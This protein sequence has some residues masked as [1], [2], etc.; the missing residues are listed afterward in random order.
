MNVLI[1]LIICLLSYLVESIYNNDSVSIYNT[2]SLSLTTT[3]LSLKYKWDSLLPPRLQWLHN[4]GY[5]GE[6][7]TIMAL[8]KYGNYLSQY[9]FRA[10]SSKYSVLGDSNKP[11]QTQFYLVGSNDEQSSLAVKLKYIEYDHSNRDPKVYLAWCKKMTRLGYAV[12]ITVYM[13]YYLFY[14]INDNTAGEWDYDHIVS[15]SKIES[16]YDDDEYHDDDIITLEDH[17][18]WAPRKTGPLYLF[19]YTFKDFPGTREEANT[20]TDSNKI[21]TLPSSLAS[22]QYGICHTGVIDDNSE[23]L[24]ITITSNVNYEAPEIDNHSEIRPASMPIV[25]TIKISSL[26][27][28]QN[29]ILYKYDDEN[30][31]PT[32]NFN[33]HKDNAISFIEFT[34]NDNDD[35]NHDSYIITDNIQS[36]QKAFYRAVKY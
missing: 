11:Q 12:T 4:D 20:Q 31:I 27:R 32:S 6:V 1:V 9:D 22:G 14:G 28:N 10:I 17:G 34:L 23:L 3:T 24:P 7:S 21:Y 8:L 36:N 2:T 19:S 33:D 35:Y 25:L 18:L 16:N 30:M 29:Y 15:I 13:N 5:C 26:L